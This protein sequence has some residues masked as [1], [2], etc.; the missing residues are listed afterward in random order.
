[1]VHVVR[2]WRLV[3]I[4]KSYKTRESAFGATTLLRNREING[5]GS[6]CYNLKFDL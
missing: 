3:S 6:Q 1:M 2:I 5:A 4:E